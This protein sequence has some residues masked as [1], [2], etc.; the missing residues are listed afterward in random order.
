M[1]LGYFLE[2]IQHPDA[3]S[4]DAVCRAVST[5]KTKY[6]G[7][8]ADQV[9]AVIKRSKDL[10]L[11]TPAAID[12]LVSLGPEAMEALAELAGGASIEL[13][14]GVPKK[15]EIEV[16]AKADGV[17]RNAANSSSSASCT[18]RLPEINREPP[19]A[20][21]CSR[22]AVAAASTTSGCPARSR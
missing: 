10:S 22:A 13:P 15:D 18:A 20:A 9:V 1:V 12:Y 19:A 14:L 17:P 16:N 3:V 5:L 4:W 2:R 8:K 7:V 6:P 21:P 11:A